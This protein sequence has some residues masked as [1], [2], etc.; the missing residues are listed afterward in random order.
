MSIKIEADR[1]SLSLFIINNSIIYARYFLHL[2]PSDIFTVTSDIINLGCIKSFFPNIFP[3]IYIWDFFLFQSSIYSIL[4]FGAKGCHWDVTFLAQSL[5][6]HL[7]T[8]PLSLEVLKSLVIYTVSLLLWN[9]FTDIMDSI[10]EQLGRPFDQMFS[11]N[12]RIFLSIRIPA[13]LTPRLF[14][15]TTQ[16]MKLLEWFENLDRIGGKNTL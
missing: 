10:T 14:V 13:P 2:F 8:T 9:F 7:P 1:S 12:E 5:R 15:L 16:V 3:N 11:E 6:M 4:H